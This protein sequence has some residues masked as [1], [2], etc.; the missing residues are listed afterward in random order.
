M[1]LPS[2]TF[3]IVSIQEI[4]TMW[5]VKYNNYIY[6]VLL[7]QVIIYIF[8]KYIMIIYYSIV[9]GCINSDIRSIWQSV[10]KRQVFYLI[11][12]ACSGGSLYQPLLYV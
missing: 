6:I 7:S 4:L 2:V 9:S 11:V 12:A 1:C 8:I 10:S 3:H 5:N